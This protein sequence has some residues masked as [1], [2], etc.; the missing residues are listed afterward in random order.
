LAGRRQGWSASRL[1]LCRLVLGAYNTINIYIISQK[2]TNAHCILH[3]HVSGIA[4]ATIH[5]TVLK[6]KL[7]GTARSF[8]SSPRPI[9]NP[10]SIRQP[11]RTRRLDR[12]PHRTLPLQR[13]RPLHQTLPG[14]LLDLPLPLLPLIRPAAP[15]IFPMSRHAVGNPPLSFVESDSLHG[16]DLAHQCF[17]LGLTWRAQFL[18]LPALVRV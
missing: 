9:I 11:R 13:K 5:A 2:K 17:P 3:N 6:R 12:R 7:T 10:N 16:Y 18:E 14:L 8:I 15:E 1:L 4:A